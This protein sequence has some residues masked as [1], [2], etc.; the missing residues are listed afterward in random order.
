MVLF[1]TMNGSELMLTRSHL[2]IARTES[3]Y[4]DCIMFLINRIGCIYNIIVLTLPA[5]DYSRIF[6]S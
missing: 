1:G 5:F 2:Q 4:I 3:L 6:S